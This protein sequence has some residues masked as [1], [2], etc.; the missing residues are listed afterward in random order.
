M[1]SHS[2]EP[3]LIEEIERLLLIGSG[4]VTA[5]CAFTHKKVILC[6]IA[7]PEST[8]PTELPRGKNSNV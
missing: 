7:I 4:C 6:A 2:L 5:N 8:N 1:S 3:G